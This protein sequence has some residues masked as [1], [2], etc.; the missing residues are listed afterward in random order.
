MVAPKKRV[1]PMSRETVAVEKEGVLNRL[2][3]N[4][5]SQDFYVL[6]HSLWDDNSKKILKEIEGWEERPSKK[7][8]TIHLI[9]SWELPH[10]FVAFSVTSVPTLV[11]CVKGRV[12]VETYL[13]NIF[14]FFSL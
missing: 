7:D 3:K 11:K 8:Q 2:I 9:N 4:K 13:P 10:S 14:R 12:F 1:P 6:Y 5:R